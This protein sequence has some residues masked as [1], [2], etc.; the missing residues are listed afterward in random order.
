MAMTAKSQRIDRLVR[1]SLTTADAASAARFYEAAFG[2]RRIAADR[3]AGPEF[4]RLMDVHGGADRI[5]LGLGCEIIEL[6]QFDVPGVTYPEDSSSSDL[7]FQHLAIVVA[8]IEQAFER[9]SCVA[10]WKPISIGGPQRLPQ[11]SG[12]VTA[13]KFRDP[14][15]HPLELLTFPDG[16][17]RRWTE[18]PA[19]EIFLGID[20]S[21]ISVS[22]SAR[23]VTF[24]QKLGL[25]VS[26]RSFNFGAA[27]ERLDDVAGA[28][29]DVTALAL[30][31]DTPHL[32]LL[33]YRNVRDRRMPV[34]PAAR[35]NDI[36]CTRL[37][38]EVP[39]TQAADSHRLMRDPDDHT[40]LLVSRAST[41]WGS[42]SGDGDQNS[43]PKTI[44]IQ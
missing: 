22:D 18:M 35:S 41:V 40:L 17:D 14:E 7:R 15:G 9:L 34:Q 32:E 3:L 25:V 28:Q 44:N 33:C 23:S 6:L 30:S 11:S 2:C 27:Q 8:D 37:V 1:F 29:V 5:T 31:C 36:A 24:Y 38:Y 43:R 4:E 42:A 19:G 20:H 39:A 16:G 13:F 10:G 26:A 12:G 21:A